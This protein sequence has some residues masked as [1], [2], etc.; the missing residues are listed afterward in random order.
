[1]TDKIEGWTTIRRGQVT[2]AYGKPF[3]GKDKIIANAPLSEEGFEALALAVAEAR[4]YWTR[5]QRGD[6]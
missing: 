2:V 4:E 6:S 1:M 3:Y 5:S